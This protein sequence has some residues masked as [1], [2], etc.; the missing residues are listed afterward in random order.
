[1]KK[2]I[3]ISIYS[4]FILL[5]LCV[6]G[7][8]PESDPLLSYSGSDVQVYTNAGSSF[9]QQFIELW[10]ALNCNYCIWDYELE[11]G[12]DWDKVYNTYLPKFQ[13]LDE[14]EDVTDDELRA[15]YEDVLN[16]LHDGHLNIQVKNLKNGHFLSFCPSD[17][18]NESRPDCQFSMTFY[19]DIRAYQDIPGDCHITEYK[20]ASSFDQDAIISSVIDDAKTC[21]L[22]KMDELD[23]KETLTDEDSIM[24]E[25]MISF[26]E[27]AESFEQHDLGWVYNTY[28]Q[29]CVQYAMLS[30]MLGF[31]M[32]TVETSFLDYNLSLEYACFEPGIAYLHISD[33]NLYPY[34]VSKSGMIDL[35]K[36]TAKTIRRAIYGTW[37][38]WW[39]K[40]QELKQSQALKG[41]IIDVRSNTGGFN[42]DFQFLL[43]VMLPT[44]TYSGHMERTK[45][46]SGRYDF[47]PLIPFVFPTYAGEHEVIDTEP[48]V[49]M[50]NGFSVSMAELTCI[51]AKSMPNARVIGKRTWGGM[52]SLNTSPSSY[53]DTYSGC[54]GVKNQTPFY[55]FI[56][57]FVSVVPE[58]GILEGVGVTPDIEVDFDQALFD[59]TGRDS[60]L[61]RA[62]QYIQTGN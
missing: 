8:R 44:G 37:I 43:G 7:C 46:G 54:F 17:N 5:A 55:A 21:I 57:K 62:I 15:L 26:L 12:L 41:V 51:C 6:T 18:R 49:V 48:V 35:S 16:P 58:E 39:D 50:C 22:A 42:N 20:E 23:Q 53:S 36:P 9:E 10:K 11:H 28:N 27:T 1:M 24:L 25:Y 32:P 30:E 29:M 4:L 47:A 31:E 56:P 3:F 14:Q 45:A 34:L 61:E 33:F 38:A 2:K 59:A 19:P 60:Q 40:I 13:A 52:C